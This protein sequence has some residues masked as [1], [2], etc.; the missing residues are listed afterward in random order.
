MNSLSNI[1]SSQQTALNARIE[2]MA[3][4][5]RLQSSVEL[6]SRMH[7]AKRAN[8]QLVACARLTRH[9][10]QQV[11]ELREENETLKSKLSSFQDGALAVRE[12]FAV[13]ISRMLAQSKDAVKVKTHMKKIRLNVREQKQANSALRKRESE[14]QD[15]VSALERT[16]TDLKQEHTSEIAALRE[17]LEAVERKESDLGGTPESSGQAAIEEVDSFFSE[18][19]VNTPPNAP[20]EGDKAKHKQEQGPT[21]ASQEQPQLAEVQKPLCLLSDTEDLELLHVFSYLDTGEVL[22]AAQ[23]NKFVFQRVDELFSLESKVAQPHW[24][25]RET[26]TA[27]KEE[28]AVTD[29]RDRQASTEK[30]ESD[31]I[32]VGSAP[33]AEHQSQNKSGVQNFFTSLA[34][35]ITNNI[36]VGGSAVLEGVDPE[37]CLLPP[38]VMDLLR[39]KLSYAEV[40]AISNLNDIAEIKIKRVEELSV[41]KEDLVQR[42][43]NTETVRDFLI[44]K[45]KSAEVALRSSLR[46]GVQHRKQ[47]AADGEIIHFLDMRN[48]ELEG[49]YKEVELKRQ[50]LQAAHDLYQSTHAHNERNLNEEVV[51]LRAAQLQADLSHKSEKKLLVREVRA[52]RASLEKI[53]NERNQLAAQVQAVTASLGIAITPTSRS[54]KK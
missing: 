20:E 29:E 47:A 18:L 40:R 39:T 6:D 1:L 2:V 19:Q 33:Q 27:A 16:L 35:T 14:L 54:R 37:L 53:T 21:T 4:L 13:D 26:S 12:R 31:S 42:L 45:L 25:L 10:F 44:T 7:D 8:A 41:E 28:S 51:S 3:P 11:I 22:A 24:K 46:E 5:D 30:K 49:Q 36:P 38:P 50:G 32:E 48:Q 43:L 23:V 15:E 34:S 9:A 17:K 52:L